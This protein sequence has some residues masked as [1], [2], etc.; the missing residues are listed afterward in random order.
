MGAS[1]ENPYAGQGPVLLD[2]GDDVGALVVVMP[3]ATEGLEVELRP[4]GATAS[5]AADPGRVDRD[6]LRTSDPHDHDQP[7]A[8]DHTHDHDHPHDHHHA[9]DH[10]QTHHHGTAGRETAVGHPAGGYQTMPGTPAA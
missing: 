4:V 10:D 2:I 7:R 5:G 1:S 3:P 8:H 9:H 6:G